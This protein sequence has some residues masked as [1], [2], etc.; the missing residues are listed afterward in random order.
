MGG[1]SEWMAMASEVYAMWD[2]ATR[3]LDE[4]L[5]AGAT[6]L[7]F[8][9]AHRDPTTSAMPLINKPSE[10]FLL[11][12]GYI[13][14]VMLWRAA[15]V[16]SGG[17][18]AGAAGKKPKAKSTKF[19]PTFQNLVVVGHNVF[20]TLLSAYMFVGVVTEAVRN[21]YGIFLNGYNPKETQMAWFIYVF[22]VSKFYEFLDTFI[23]LWK[24]NV[25]QVSFLHVYHHATIAPI[26]YVIAKM[27][28]GGEAYWSAAA[29]SL[30]HVIMYTYYCCAA[31]KVDK[32]YLTWAK[33][34]TMFQMAQ[35]AMNMVQAAV[36]ITFD[37]PYMH[38][39]THL[40]FYYMITLLFL[41]GSF[42]VNK[43]IKGGAKKPTKGA[44]A[45]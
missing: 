27:A 40:L 42:F 44:K 1:A 18:A 36:D 22:Y 34:L 16:A 45:A 35:F 24:G 3:P 5:T 6:S 43:Y 25:A 4:W 14:A 20:L 31:L 26:W 33:Y 21:K 29:N 12:V 11:I 28:P 37:S 7:G 23:M 2:E 41:F 38:S 8:P 13:A 19:E 15:L 10:P 9:L 39:L 32:K 17:G 30:V